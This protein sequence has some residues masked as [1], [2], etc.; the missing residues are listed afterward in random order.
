MLYTS[1]NLISCCTKCK[2]S[3]NQPDEHFHQRGPSWWTDINFQW[4][5]ISV[6]EAWTWLGGR[7]SIRTV[8]KLSG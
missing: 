7:K 2:H 5:G 8:K 4:Y 6:R 1:Q 3:A